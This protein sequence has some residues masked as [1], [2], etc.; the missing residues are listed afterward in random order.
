M[1]RKIIINVKK[2]APIPSWGGCD[3][4]YRWQ[5]PLVEHWIKENKI[6]DK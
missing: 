2:I 5:I 6:L 3:V 1:Y 4:D